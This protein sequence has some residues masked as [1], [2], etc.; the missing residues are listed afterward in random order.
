VDGGA[1]VEQFL[2][3]I[4]DDRAHQGVE[5]RQ[6][7]ESVPMP[8]SRLRIEDETNGG[9]WGRIIFVTCFA[10]IFVALLFVST[11]TSDTPQWRPWQLFLVVELFS[12]V[13]PWAVAWESMAEMNKRRLIDIER[14]WLAAAFVVTVIQALSVA[15]LVAFFKL[16]A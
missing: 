2:E 7:V 6:C 14:V 12:G 5:N 13:L 11:P 4:R 8:G 9:L 3:A 10:S 16:I 1:A 15:A